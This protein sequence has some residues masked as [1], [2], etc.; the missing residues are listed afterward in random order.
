MANSACV[1]ALLSHSQRKIT[2]GITPR[3]GV[4]NAN[5]KWQKKLIMNLNENVYFKFAYIYLKLK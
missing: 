1:A 5:E 3:I 2:N 4:G